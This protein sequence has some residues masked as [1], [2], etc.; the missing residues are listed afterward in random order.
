[1]I[2]IKQQMVK[3]GLT[4]LGTDILKTIFVCKRQ[5]AYFQQFKLLHFIHHL[6]PYMKA[7]LAITFLYLLIFNKMTKA[8][9]LDSAA[10]FN[11][12]MWTYVKEHPTTNL[13]IH[14]DKNIY[15]P[16]E[17][18]W[19]KA[20]V[21]SGVVA[22]NKVLYVRL[23]DEKNKVILSSQFPMNN[24]LANG[25]LLL[26]DTLKD[27]KYFLYAYG[28]RMINFDEKDVFVQPVMVYKNK[29]KWRAEAY[30]IDTS[31]LVRGE[32]V[33][34][35]VRLKQNND[36][37]KNVRGHYQFFDGAKV[38]KQGGLKTNIVG[39]AFIGFTYP[40]IGD[41][42]MLNAVITFSDENDFEEVTVNLRHRA[43][44][45][46]ANC[47][48]GGGHLIGNLQNRLAVEVLDVNNLPVSTTV[49]LLADNI[50]IQT[51]VSDSSGI[52][53]F[54]F[55][56][57]VAKEYSIELNNNGRAEVVPFRQSIESKGW[58]MDA[59]VIKSNCHVHLHNYGFGD[60]VTLVLR[61]FEQVLWTKG[62]H[63]AD[64]KETD[65]IIPLDS[66]QR[67]VFSIA[68]LG[69]EQQLLAEQ[70]FVYK[71]GIDASV[72]IKTDKQVYETRKKVTVEVNVFDANGNPLPTNFSV[73][74]V[75]V[76]TIDSAVLP[77]IIAA[78]LFKD[79]G[80][81]SPYLIQHNA[82]TDALNRLLLTKTWNNYH[83]QNILNYLPKGNLKIYRN[84]DGVFG[85][86]ASIYKKKKVAITEL[87][88]L[89]KEG[90][91][92]VP[93]SEHGDFDIPSEQL[94]SPRNEKKSL[95]LGTD[96]Y[97]KYT[98]SFKNYD[99][100]FDK[101]IGESNA[102]NFPKVFTG[103][104]KYKMEKL[105]KLTDPHQLQNV[106]VK[107]IKDQPWTATDY[108]S[109]NC[110]DYVCMNNI[111]NCPNHKWGTTPIVGE[112]YRFRDKRIVYRGGCGEIADET[113]PVVPLKLIMVPNTF[114][115]IDF[116]KETSEEKETRT[117]IYWNPNVFTD[118]DGKA[119]FTFFTDDV[120]GEFKIIL[121]GV[122]LHGLL[123]VYSTASFMVK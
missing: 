64:K 49:K 26:P 63:V 112:T 42:K 94:M 58:L 51:L 23:T 67:Q 114:P 6:M 44:T 70:L 98:I 84:T 116:E 120:T 115:V 11:N 91:M 7:R 76:N 47:Y 81:N 32:K 46:K 92:M 18:M 90:M 4:Y 56:P 108:Y 106:V 53:V 28:D 17:R 65:I 9:D 12:Q 104:S 27:G 16:N 29:K 87:P 88:V 105:E 3:M 111:F 13:F 36:L 121:Q 37:V 80:F 50:I 24:L 54:S 38:V 59:K 35:L 41:D 33:E 14:T 101:K 113:R 102:F 95:F 57:S 110:M 15:S 72:Q 66:F 61:S 117:T 123:P 103:L 107:V 89:S 30:V 109:P 31:K 2:K 119:T 62:M 82:S 39:E 86:I 100:D 43:N 60:S 69:P 99:K 52:A 55:V 78:G 122:S 83:W 20:Y 97:K 25:D 21:L 71:P 34:M 75:E 19:F 10:L 79:I 96:F 74:A 5:P 1:M 68:A 118:K 73:A 85:N 45:L 8:G 48:P 40:D 93:L 77:N 22:D